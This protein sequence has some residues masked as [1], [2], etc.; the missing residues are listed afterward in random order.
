MN[1]LSPHFSLE[2]L[3]HSETAIRKGIDNSASSEIYN[4]LVSLAGRLEEVR[5]ILGVSLRIS[6]GY[7]CSELN[8]VIGGSKS[9]AHVQGY[10]AD[11]QCSMKPIE[12][13]KR[14]ND[15]DINFDQLIEEGTWTHISFDPRMRRQVL[16][17]KFNNGSVSYSEGLKG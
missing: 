2:E 17:A 8:K 1:Q 16:T 14:L 10:A 11:F 6:S 7:R 13:C 3:T 9:S 15:A 4:R 12:V 5:T